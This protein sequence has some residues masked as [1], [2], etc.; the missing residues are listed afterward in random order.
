M[1]SLPVSRADADAIPDRRKRAGRRATDLDGAY[2]DGGSPTPLRLAN[3][4][5]LY[6]ALGWIVI[7]SA[8]GTLFVLKNVWSFLALLWTHGSVG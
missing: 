6:G 3:A 5:G 8:I 2:N 1:K 7:T 4:I